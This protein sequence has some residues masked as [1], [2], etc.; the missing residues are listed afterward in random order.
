[1]SD[2][3]KGS[4][5][6]FPDRETTSKSLWADCGGSPC[7]VCCFFTYPAPPHRLIV[8]GCFGGKRAYLDVAMEEA[9]RRFNADGPGPYD[10]SYMNIDEFTFKDEFAA[11]DAWDCK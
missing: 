8:I 4:C 1:M 2:D 9:L 6:K 11:Y 10:E 5:S 3:V 7:G